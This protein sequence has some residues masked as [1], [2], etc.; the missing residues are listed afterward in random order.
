MPS[1]RRGI[2]AGTRSLAAF[3]M[4]LS[5][6]ARTAPARAAGRPAESRRRPQAAARPESP[7]TTAAARA[8]STPETRA[9]RLPDSLQIS[10]S[11]S[12]ARRNSIA[13]ACRH[14]HPDQ[15]PRQRLGLS[16]AAIDDLDRRVAG[17]LHQRVIPHDVAETEARHARL[18]RAEKLA[19]AAELEIALGH[20]EAA[21]RP[22][23]ELQALLLLVRHENA[24]RLSR[25]APDA[26]AELV[27]LREAVAVGV[28]DEH[29]R[30]VRHVDAD[31][32]HRRGDEHVE[33]AALEE[34]HRLFFLRGAHPT[35]QHGHAALAEALAHGVEALHQRL[36]VQ[37]LRLLDDR[38]DDVRLRAALELLVDEGVDAV[39]VRRGAHRRLHR[40][41]STRQLVD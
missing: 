31:L 20:L 13:L 14:R 28:D 27:E 5:S 41:T 15:P 40:G 35:V 25:A 23:E 3:G 17:L 10:T 1:R 8:A 7:R 29:D 32:D 4:T 18:L 34:L 39:E 24:V 12:C 19:G 2:P 9:G 11:I 22:G 6:A 37:L 16:H 30:G 33:L 36:H 21:A 38:E 26:A